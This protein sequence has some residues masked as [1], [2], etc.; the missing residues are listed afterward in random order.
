[1]HNNNQH[2][3]NQLKEG[4]QHG[5]LARLVE[6]ELHIDEYKSKMGEDSD[7]ITLSFLVREKSGAEDLVSF[8]ESG[9][10]WVLD[11]DV[12]SGELEPGWYLV[13][14]EIERDKHAPENIYKLISEILNL[15]DQT[16]E[17]WHFKYRRELKRHDITIENITSIVPTT[18][19]EF[20]AE[21]N[22]R[23][24]DKMKAAAGV[25]V[26]TKAPRNA[27]TDALRTAAGII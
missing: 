6:P 22:N 8:I 26:S 20:N 21:H 13:F 24:I 12:S 19:D 3:S 18:A 27:D 10:N 17:D 4:V 7:I 11:A 1:M 5:D 9:Y 23:D 14:V 16:I 15:T 2:N 25:N